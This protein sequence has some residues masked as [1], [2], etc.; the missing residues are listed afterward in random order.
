M[1][2]LHLYR[3]QYTMIIPWLVS[4]WAGDIGMGACV[5]LLQLASCGSVTLRCIGASPAAFGNL[6]HVLTSHDSLFMSIFGVRAQKEDTI[7]HEHCWG[8]LVTYSLNLLGSFVLNGTNGGLEGHKEPCMF[9]GDL[10]IAYAHACAW[11]WCWTPAVRRL[12]CEL[13]INILHKSSSMGV[14]MNV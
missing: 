13:V 11:S 2:G 14:F 4:F 1:R 10:N 12:S 5:D 3:Q 9:A 7:H 6:R 8:G